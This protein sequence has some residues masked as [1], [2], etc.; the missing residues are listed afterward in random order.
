ML[1]EMKDKT[2]TE[3]QMALMDRVIT[4]ATARNLEANLITMVIKCLALKVD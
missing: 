2:D 1:V 4:W 3:I